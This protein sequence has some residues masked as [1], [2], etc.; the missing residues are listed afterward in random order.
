MTLNLEYYPKLKAKIT[1]VYGSQTAFADKIGLQPITV[2]RRLNGK[3]A[4]TRDEIMQWA[5]VLGI[6]KNQ[7]ASY[8]FD[9]KVGG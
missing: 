1:E 4:F 9:V 2:S 3:T 6:K 7:I 8:F 5:G